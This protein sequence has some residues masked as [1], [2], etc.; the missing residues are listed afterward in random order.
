VDGGVG[1]GTWELWGGER[2]GWV[3]GRKEGNRALDV[4]GG[5]GGERTLEVVRWAV[6]GGIWRRDLRAVG[7]RENGLG[8]W[9]KGRKTG[10]WT[11][12]GAGEENGRWWW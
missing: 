4:R 10:R 6:D 3:S 2:M 8:E 11:Y 9:E 1:R 5:W 12:E 7:R